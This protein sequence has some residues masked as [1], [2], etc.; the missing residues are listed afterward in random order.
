M[1]ETIKVDFDAILQF[2]ALESE[3]RMLKKVEAGSDGVPYSPSPQLEKRIYNAVRG[4]KTKQR[5]KKVRRVLQRVGICCCV[6]FTLAGLVFVPVQAVQQAVIN[7]VMEWYD[8]FTS[9]VFKSDGGKT[10]SA[11]PETLRVTYWPQG[12]DTLI[13]EYISEEVIS[14]SYETKTKKIS[15]VYIQI[16]DDGAEMSSD[17]EHTQHYQITFDNITA[18]WGVSDEAR[19]SLTW[20]SDG[21]VFYVSTDE[22]LQEAIKIAQGIVL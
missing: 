6:L 20:A 21:Y 17:N 22:S 18:I 13:D 8:G 19:N 15:S 16:I 3:A 12:Y 7:T 4:E 9:F 11:L 14:R 1:K 2:A 10:P 5:H